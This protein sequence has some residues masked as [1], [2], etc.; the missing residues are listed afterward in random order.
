M[1]MKKINQNNFMEMN[2]QKETIRLVAFK[3][4][5]KKEVREEIKALLLEMF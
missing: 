3:K 2:T 4:R 5:K 1:F